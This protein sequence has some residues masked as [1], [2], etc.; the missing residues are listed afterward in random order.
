MQ[1]L[2]LLGVLNV[3]IYTQLETETE[4]PACS[5]DQMRYNHQKCKGKYASHQP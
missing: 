4:I 5:G 2:E 3:A 1:Q